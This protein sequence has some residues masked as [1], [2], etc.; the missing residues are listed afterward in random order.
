MCDMRVCR[1]FEFLVIFCYS[2]WRCAGRWFIIFSR[3]IDFLHFLQLITAKHYRWRQKLLL[4]MPSRDEVFGCNLFENQL[5]ENL[6]FILLAYENLSSSKS[7]KAKQNLECQVIICH[8]G[9]YSIYYIIIK[10]CRFY[11]PPQPRRFVTYKCIMLKTEHKI[12]LKK[13]REIK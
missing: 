3:S 12:K 11:L 8:H 9:D 2:A 13:V 4:S 6:S 7:R 5:Y 1:K 10:S